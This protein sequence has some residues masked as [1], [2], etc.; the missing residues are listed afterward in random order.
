MI[1]SLLG[2]LFKIYIPGPL[3]WRIQNGFRAFRIGPKKLRPQENL[4]QPISEQNL[5][6]TESLLKN[7]L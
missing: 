4:R 1:A 7:S 5:G 3:G 2:G 6:N